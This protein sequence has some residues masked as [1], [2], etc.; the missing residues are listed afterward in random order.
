METKK[1][2]QKQKLVA[3]SPGFEP[4][5]SPDGYGLPALSYVIYIPVSKFICMYVLMFLRPIFLRMVMVLYVFPFCSTL[6]L[7]WSKAWPIIE[8]TKRGL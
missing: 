4:G 3:V 8:Q 1:V 6:D 7:C 5:S 2:Q